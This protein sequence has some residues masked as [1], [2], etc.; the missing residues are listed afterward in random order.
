M[1][2]TADQY[3]PDPAKV[4]SDLCWAC[5]THIGSFGQHITWRLPTQVLE[6]KK[7][8]QLDNGQRAQRIY[9]KTGKDQFPLVKDYQDE[10][11]HEGKRIM[12]EKLCI[13][14]IYKII[15]YQY[16]PDIQISD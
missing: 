13:D 7:V 8:K 9:E 12:K 15:R 2:I 10:T 16:N 1:I 11:N 5:S 6:E 3:Q 14:Y 4:P